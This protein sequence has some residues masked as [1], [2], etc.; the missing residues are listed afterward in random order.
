[1]IAAPFQ[2]EAQRRY[3]FANRPA[4]A[5]AWAHGLSSVTGRKD[6]K[7]R[8]ARGGYKNLPYHKRP[9]KRARRS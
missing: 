3:L 2:S 1:M 5:H 4:Q 8:G 7:G 6:T 9:A